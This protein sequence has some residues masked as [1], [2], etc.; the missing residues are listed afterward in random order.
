VR[1]KL[2]VIVAVLLCGFALLVGH[3]VS[4][5]GAGIR[6]LSD[7]TRVLFL[8]LGTYIQAER[9]SAALRVLVL[10]MSLAK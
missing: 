3:A 4:P 9:F 10:K 8:R 2:T 6:R 1:L 7:S 5:E